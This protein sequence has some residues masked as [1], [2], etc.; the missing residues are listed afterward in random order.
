[1]TTVKVHYNR[2]KK[3]WAIKEGSKPTYYLDSLVLAN[4]KWVVQRGGSATA[5]RTKQRNVH[6]YVKGRIVSH[7]PDDAGATGWSCVA[8]YNPFKDDT[9]K[10]VLGNK[11]LK[12]RF[13]KFRTDGRAYAYDYH[14]SDHINP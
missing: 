4:C 5:K 6:A 1:M 13:T 10:D 9:F 2:P 11:V 7:L 12:S 14:E 8:H 3:M